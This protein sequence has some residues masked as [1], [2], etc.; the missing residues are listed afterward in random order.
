MFL[1][2][3]SICD[4]LKHTQ[5]CPCKIHHLARFEILPISLWNHDISILFSKYV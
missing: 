2:S 3:K 4:Q 1:N 5:I